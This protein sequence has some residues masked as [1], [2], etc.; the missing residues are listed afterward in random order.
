[1]PLAGPAGDS[2]ALVDARGRRW[3]R[4]GTVGQRTVTPGGRGG[5]RGAGIKLSKKQVRA[6]GNRRECPN[7]PI[8]HSKWTLETAAI[9]HMK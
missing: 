2:A 5:R 6:A 9:S 4:P 3:L 1:M 8:L 7:Q